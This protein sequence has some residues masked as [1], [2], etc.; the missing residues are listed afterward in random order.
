MPGLV[1]ISAL[2]LFRCLVRDAL[3]I[4]VLYSYRLCSAK[5]MRLRCFP[6]VFFALLLFSFLFLCPW[7][8]YGR[9]I[10]SALTF[11][12]RLGW[13]VGYLSHSHKAPSTV[14]RTPNLLIFDIQYF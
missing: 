14:S 13:K 10:L 8:L 6:F 5:L 3:G 4:D 12:G 1:H 7:I 2:L 11:V 9:Y